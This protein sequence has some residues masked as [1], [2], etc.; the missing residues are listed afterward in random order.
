MMPSANWFVQTRFDSKKLG[1]CVALLLAV[2]TALVYLPVR[3]SEFIS[4]DDPDYVT[5]N[6]EVKAGL[7]FAGLKWALR[8]GQAG[9]WHP[10]TWLSHMLD[11]QVFGLNSTGHHFTNLLLH[12]ANTLLL[13]AL[14]RRMTG[15]LWRSA[16]V[17]G[18]F[19]LHPLHVESVAW[20][21]ERK[22][23]LSAFFFFLTLLAYHAYVRRS[24]GGG[25]NQERGKSNQYSVI[26][27]QGSRVYYALALV[28]FALGLMSKPMLVTLPFVLLLLDWWPLGRF[29]FAERKPVPAG[30]ETP[31]MESETN[32]P[33]APPSKPRPT[34]KLL[35]VEKA[36][37]FALTVISSVVT[38]FA[39]K[40]GGAVQ[41]LSTMSVSVRWENAVVSYLRYLGKTF[42]PFDLAAP[43]PHPFHWPWLLIICSGLILLAGTGAAFGTRRRFPF[44]TTGWLWF[45]GMM[46]PVIGIIQVGEQSMADRYTYLPLIGV[47]IILAWGAA[48]IAGLTGPAGQSKMI[49]ERTALSPA[50]VC[51][52]IAAGLTLLGCAVRARDQVRYW[53]DSEALF[54]HAV[55]VTDKNWI[56]YY[57]LG[58]VQDQHGQAEQALVNYHKA[59]ALQ[60]SFDEAWNNLGCLLAARKDYAEAIP[61]FE[62]VT[63][64]KPNDLDGHRNLGRALIEVGRSDEAIPHYRR[65]VERKPD[66]TEALNSLGNSLARKGQ[67][68]EAATYYQASL[69]V[70]NNQAATHYNLAN[71]LVRMRR[72]DEGIAE[73]K[74]ALQQQPDYPNAQNDLG[75]ALARE[76]K[77]A[78]ATP[79]LQAAVRGRTNDPMVRVNLGKVL[80]AQ[81][82]F[83]EAIPVYH[84][85]LLLSPTN[86]EA[87][88]NLGVALAIK[89]DPAQAVP[90]LQEALKY[91]PNDPLTHF[92]LGKAFANQGQT[93][94][95]LAQFTDALRL[96]PNYTEARREIEALGGKP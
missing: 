59:I 66:D 57:N 8:T 79:Y 84:E 70:K 72:L 27:N 91:R 12:I 56:A 74:I 88:A 76:G 60:P 15:T 14:L 17:A 20:I 7:S 65:V 83:D 29:K 90:H 30:A 58:W 42:W 4:Y 2:A 41:P 39:Q 18:L 3:H 13:F 53:H 21:A 43:Y 52:L 28:C 47:F 40:E 9:N 69:R 34:L 49:R 6:P 45:V 55:T 71:S 54:R 50:G 38:F 22:D 35:L 77:F 61:C 37:F 51:A 85:A 62:T 96:R 68:G 33:D 16:F 73:Y 32:V 95:A 46:V 78:E 82:K 75:M 64:L 94:E 31:E 36:P 23:L 80:S 24:E 44:F 89:G 25:S 92:N 67:F 81:Q 5:N 63:R 26:S 86:A 87:H 1:A 93:N 19:A 48:E 11:V 10:V